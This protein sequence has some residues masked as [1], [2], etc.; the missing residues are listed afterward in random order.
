[1]W[2]KYNIFR[3]LIK[4][5]VRQRLNSDYHRHGLGKYGRQCKIVYWLRIRLFTNP[6]YAQICMYQYFFQFDVHRVR[7]FWSDQIRQL[8]R[9]TDA[10]TKP[11]LAVK[12][13]S[14]K[15]FRVPS[16]D[17]SAGRIRGS[18]NSRISFPKYRSPTV[19]PT[20]SHSHLPPSTWSPAQMVKATLWKTLREAATIPK[21]RKATIRKTMIP[22]VQQAKR[23]LIRNTNG[24]MNTWKSIAPPKSR[25]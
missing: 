12:I 23:A 4:T 5:S 3:N 1:M 6:K 8:V 24:S 15:A 10:S 11:T 22:P 7:P 19:K 18:L 16:A 25:P 21:A 13:T 9:P 2:G 14:Q 20:R 17:P